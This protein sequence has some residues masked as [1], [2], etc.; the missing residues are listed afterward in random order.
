[1]PLPRD[2]AALPKNRYEFLQ[3]YDEDTVN[4]HDDLDR[5]DDSLG[6]KK[7]IQLCYPA[8]APIYPCHLK[9]TGRATW[10]R[11]MLL[12][13]GKKGC[14]KI[15][16][17]SFHLVC[18]PT[19]QKTYPTF[20]VSG[21]AELSVTDSIIADCSSDASGGF[22]RAYDNAVVMIDGSAISR[23]KVLFE[24]VDVLM[25]HKHR[26]SNPALILRSLSTLCRVS[27]MSLDLLLLI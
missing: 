6:L 11:V 27:S 22:V 15:S 21:G 5:P 13:D 26:S 2:D 18:D 1:V 3:I 20:E 25:H 16:M 19:E 4:G 23:S 7:Q 12:C 10:W 14:E 8:N 9:L 17:K 24:L